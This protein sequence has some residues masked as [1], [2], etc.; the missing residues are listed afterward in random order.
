MSK[1]T[2]KRDLTQITHN[3]YIH[4]FR[5]S[6]VKF[7]DT[8]QQN[9]HVPEQHE[10]P[11]GCTFVHLRQNDHIAHYIHSRLTIIIILPSN[12]RLFDAYFT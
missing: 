4:V 5:E 10:R 7:P 6:D 3:I 12:M 2:I 11:N 1:S 9:V 8:R